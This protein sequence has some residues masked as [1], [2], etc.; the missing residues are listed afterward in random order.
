MRI[1]NLSAL[2]ALL[3]CFTAFSPF[4]HADTDDAG[5]EAFV[6]RLYDLALQR[7]PDEAGLMQWTS[8][9]S[10][11]KATGISVA[12]GFIYS[13][14]YQSRNMSDEDYTELMYRMFF[15][16]ESDPEGKAS[17]LSVLDAHPGAEGREELFYGFA[18]SQEFSDLCASYGIIRGDYIIGRNMDSVNGINLFVDRLYRLVLGRECDMPGM[19]D[20]TRSLAGGE[21]TGTGAAYG[22][23]FSPEYEGRNRSSEEY[24]EDLYNAFMGRASD[25]AGRQ[26]WLGVIAGGASREE[27]FNGFA[28]SSEFAA[29][30][31]SYGILRGDPIRISGGHVVCIDPGHSSVVASGV[32]PLGPGSST[33][34]LADTSGTYGRWSHT[35]EYEL[36]LD[37]AILLRAEL[38]SRGY[39]VVMTREDNNTPVDCV[40]R[41]RIAN[42]NAELSVRLH[43]DALDNSSANGAVAIC[44][45]DHNPWNPQT[46][47]GSRLLADS[48]ISEYCSATGI[49]NRGVSEQDDMTGNNWS[50]VPCVLFEMGFMTNYS[51]DM[52]MNDPSFRTRMVTGLANGI[53]RYFENA[54]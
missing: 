22:F 32:V 12:Y 47:S 5:I 34:K 38:E 30:C 31:E 54:S 17:W 24:V 13:P 36:N 39:T 16:R 28:M 43:A 3:F 23:F 1:R 2:F 33:T 50:T 46:Y 37:I 14:E 19:T 8:L 53:D 48:L 29:I 15:G 25:E 44:I 49:R 6:T 21:I 35:H 4:A 40:T 42:E 9:L 11:R 7:Q 27:V 52:N 41:A 45:T 51:D 18:A 10:E 20:W 26:A